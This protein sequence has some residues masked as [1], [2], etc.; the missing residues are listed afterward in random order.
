MKNWNR[1]YRNWRYASQRRAVFVLLVVIGCLSTS[2]R[3]QRTVVRERIVPVPQVKIDTTYHFI[4]GR[5]TIF[6]IETDS[7]LIET[8][9]R[10]TLIEQHIETKPLYINVRDT[11]FDAQ[12]E[13]AK[14]QNKWLKEENKRLKKAD[15]TANKP[16][17]GWLIVYAV[18]T[19]VVIGWLWSRKRKD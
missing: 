5:D 13:R 9:I 12:T 4:G 2:C 7:I 6:R 11:I 15:E 19:A 17:T 8:I 16:S 3:Q 10:D 18:G 14:E 1:E